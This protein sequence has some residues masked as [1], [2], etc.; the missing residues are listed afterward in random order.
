V[1]ADLSR[2]PVAL[3]CGV[4]VVSVARLALMKAPPST[5]MPAGL[6]TMTSAR[7]PA[8]SNAPR[9]WVG[10]PLVISLRMTRAGPV[11][12]QGLAWTVPPSWVCAPLR[13]LLRI[14]PLRWMSNW[15]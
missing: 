5:A 1:H 12:S 8:T 10:L 2:L 11:A 15:L 6:A 7:W 9:I 4:P 13:L 14:A 3:N